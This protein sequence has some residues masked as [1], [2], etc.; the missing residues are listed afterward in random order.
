MPAAKTKPPL[1][2]EHEP[3]GAIVLVTKIEGHRVVL[4]E[5]PP[6]VAR[7]LLEDHG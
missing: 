1:V 2:V 5:I 3:G 6:N 4:V 7:H